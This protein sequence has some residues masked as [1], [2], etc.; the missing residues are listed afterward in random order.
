M[1]RTYLTASSCCVAEFICFDS[2][3]PAKI[4][5][6][7]PK[8]AAVSASLEPAAGD[9]VC[10]NV[11][12]DFHPGEADS[13]AAIRSQTPLAKFGGILG[14]TFQDWRALF[15]SSSFCSRFTMSNTPPN[16]Q[17]LKLFYAGPHSRIWLSAEK[18]GS[19]RVFSDSGVPPARMSIA[20]DVFEQ[21]PLKGYMKASLLS[22]LVVVLASAGLAP[23]TNAI[24]YS[25]RLANGANQ[26]YRLEAPPNVEPSKAPP[27]KYKMSPQLAA[28][29]AVAWAGGV[30]PNASK[31]R[32]TDLGGATPSGFYNASHISVDSV[33]YQT[34]PV[35]YYLVKM[36][37]Q[38]SQ[39]RET[40]YA[41]V[42]EDGRVVN[43]THVSGPE[44]TKAARPKQHRR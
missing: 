8:V 38:I 16:H 7:K 32:L 3:R 36:N 10:R 14:S 31:P 28:V 41:A 43:P 33:D 20:Q 9:R 40:F 23:T 6:A 42:L 2:V 4:P 26:S 12:Q 34:G 17:T 37:G 5:K 30:S 19:V 24:T 1:E 27:S 39:G 15:N 18:A 11:I 25:V 44:Q 21:P 35:P 29:A 22:I 13:R